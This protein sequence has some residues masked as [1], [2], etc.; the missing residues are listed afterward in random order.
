MKEINLL[1]VSSVN[2]ISAGVV[3]GIKELE[4]LLFIHC[5]HS[6]LV[7]FITNVHGTEADGRNMDAGERGKLS[8][9]SK[10]GGRF[11]GRA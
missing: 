8:V 5:S 2:E 11:G 6:D 7:P 3:E 10:L 9:V 4:A 1:V